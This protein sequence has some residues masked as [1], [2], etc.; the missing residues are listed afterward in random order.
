MRK[1]FGFIPLLFL[2]PLL[3]GCPTLTQVETALSTKVPTAR[4][5]A[6]ANAA[7]PPITAATSYL[8]YCK[9]AKQPAGCDNRFIHATLIPYTDKAIEARNAAVAWVKANPDATYG[10]SS[11]ISAIQSASDFLSKA[12]DQAQ[13]LKTGATNG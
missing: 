7:N 11:L 2:L 9:P 6:A 13:A 12:D 3:A 10:P 8:I 4:I 1:L 5:I